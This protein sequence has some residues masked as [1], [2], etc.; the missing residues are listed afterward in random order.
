MSLANT[1]LFEFGMTG[2]VGQ[3]GHANPA[4]H[5]KQSASPI[6]FI[7]SIDKTIDHS[8]CQVVS[9]RIG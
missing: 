1:L 9:L 2:R 7:Y 6:A 8:A 3:T 5:G 4:N